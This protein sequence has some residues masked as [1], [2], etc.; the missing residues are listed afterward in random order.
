MN[1]RLYVVNGSHPCATVRAA[2]ELKGISYATV[3]LIPPLH[4]PVMRV[5][6]GRRTVPAAK[7]DGEKISGSRAILRRLDELVPEPALLPREAAARDRVLAAEAWGDEILQ[8]L[9]RR[10]LWPTFR[11]HPEAMASFQT[12]SRLPAMP[13]G[14][15][16]LIA[17]GATRIEMRLNGATD[18]TYATD[19]RALPAL[20]DQ[21]DAWIAEGVLGGAEANVADLQIAPSLRL[22]M[23]FGD[24]RTLIEPRPAGALALRLF[25]D[26]P[27]DAPSGLIPPALLAS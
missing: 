14:V 24:L 16:K 10:I 3:E 13:V 20:L 12:G 6:F 2:L 17:P 1:V 18:A 25:A 22:L 15:L 5:L 8:P 23:S 21:V 27:G 26:F 11:D 4:A 9:V 7:I 19:L